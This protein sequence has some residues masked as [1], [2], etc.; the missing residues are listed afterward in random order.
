MPPLDSRAVLLGK[1]R[2][3]YYAEIYQFTQ[4]LQSFEGQSK[5]AV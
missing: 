4:S 1:S 3:E 2:T 5:K